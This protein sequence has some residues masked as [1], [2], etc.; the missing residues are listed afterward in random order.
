MTLNLS[1]SGIDLP[2]QQPYFHAT[3]SERITLHGST[4]VSSQLAILFPEISSPEQ[5]TVKACWNRCKIT[6]ELTDLFLPHQSHHVVF[7]ASWSMLLETLNYLFSPQVTK[8]S[9]ICVFSVL[10][11]L[12]WRFIFFIFFTCLTPFCSYIVFLVQPSQ[13][14]QITPVMM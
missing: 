10:C 8:L 13:T 6:Y 12:C 3:S 7:P 14:P 4:A 9:L 1:I 2:T 5:T 11:S